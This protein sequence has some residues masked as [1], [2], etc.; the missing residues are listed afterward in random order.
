M[1]IAYAA[2]QEFHRRNVRELSKTIV[3]EK[4]GFGNDWDR[5]EKA[6]EKFEKF[7]A[8]DSE[9]PVNTQDSSRR[10]WDLMRSGSLPA[11]H[12]AYIGLNI[13]SASIIIIDIS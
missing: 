13:R 5:A 11:T 6:L 7:L 8:S 9:L 2:T 1:S 4:L 3:K 12:K 10:L